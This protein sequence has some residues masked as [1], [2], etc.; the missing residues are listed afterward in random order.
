MTCI[1]LNKTHG[2]WARP[3]LEAFL[4]RYPTAESLRYEDP[5]RIKSDYFYR[6][7]LYR[8]A[9]WLVTLANQLILDPPRPNILR[10]KLYKDAGYACEVAHLAGVGAY[11]CDAWRLFCKRSFYA[12]HGAT[13]LDEWR[14]LIPGDVYLRRYVVHKRQQERQAMAAVL[15]EETLALRLMALRLADD[16]V[17]SRK[18]VV[19]SRESTLHVPDRIVH[20]AVVASVVGSGAAYS[21]CRMAEN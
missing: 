3:F 5:A 17:A 9:Y 2:D 21:T 4:E 19:R 16:F 11:A 6:L 12:Q 10:R 15:D 20:H 18:V 13:I 1:F 8:R 14:I 7:G